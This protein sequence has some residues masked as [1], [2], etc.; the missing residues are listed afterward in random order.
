MSYRLSICIPTYN[1]EVYLENLL[2]SIREQ[3]GN[4]ARVQI[5]VSDNA[6][7]DDT[8]DVVAR[9]AGHPDFLCVRQ[10]A[11]CGAQENVLRV[12]AAAAGEYCWLLG[13]DEKIAPGAVAGVLLLIDE[14]NPD[15]LHIST[16]DD[17]YT[18][19]ALSF[20]KTSEYVEHYVRRG[21]YRLLAM[22]LIS[23]MIFRRAVWESVP[24]KERWIPTRYLQSIAMAVA[25]RNG[26]RIVIVPDRLVIVR[27]QRA[28]FA[29]SWLYSRIPFLHLN[30]LLHLAAIADS[31]ELRIYCR[32]RRRRALARS[33]VD[34]A[35]L[36]AR[37][38]RDSGRIISGAMRTLF[39]RM[40]TRL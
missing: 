8:Q 13:D 40:P 39:A 38:L 36:V 23:T 20:G 16:R 3:I 18:D 11:N 12:V 35:R 25:L 26:G 10:E 9:Y 32:S 37:S 24:A 31:G 30:Y 14:H 5:V 33:A 17:V 19:E 15:L 28:A 7:D 29:E 6:S 2:A 4:D 21:P 1:R 34:L 22:T 27:R